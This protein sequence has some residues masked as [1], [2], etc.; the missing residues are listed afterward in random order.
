MAGEFSGGDVNT[1]LRLVKS[2]S[3]DGNLQL[4]ILTIALLTA[5]RSCGVDKDHALQVIEGAFDN[6][7]ELVPLDSPAATGS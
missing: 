2:L 5:C 4:S 7:P 1:V 3:D 6:P